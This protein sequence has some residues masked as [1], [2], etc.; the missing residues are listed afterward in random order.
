MYTYDPIEAAGFTASDPE[1]KLILGGEAAMWAETIDPTN[2]DS[3]LW[4]R[5]GAVAEVLWSGRKD[6]DGQNRTQLDA[7]PRLADMRERMVAR[8]VGAAPVQMLW[9]HQNDP[10]A[11]SL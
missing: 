5:T 10:K 11:C 7:A 1:A 9:C 4:P 8:G 3:L 2:M 6:A